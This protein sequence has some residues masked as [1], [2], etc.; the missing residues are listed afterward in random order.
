MDR[1]KP[2]IECKGTKKEGLK[3]QKKSKVKTFNT[4]KE[5]VEDMTEMIL[6][7]CG[8]CFEKREFDDD[9]TDFGCSKIKSVTA[10]STKP[11]FLPSRGYEEAMQRTFEGE[12]ALYSHEIAEEMKRTIKAHYIIAGGFTSDL[13]RLSEEVREEEERQLRFVQEDNETGDSHCQDETNVSEATETA[14]DIQ[15]FGF[16]K[17]VQELPAPTCSYGQFQAEQ[18]LSRVEKEAESRGK[19]GYKDFTK[20]AIGCGALALVLFAAY[21]F[22][23]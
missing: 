9:Y 12:S 21:R 17:Y 19:C 8:L 14:A 6:S 1:R 7:M 16:M 22:I 20:A 11:L 2:S 13:K 3:K 10:E 15:E 18:I 5:R 4:P 23:R